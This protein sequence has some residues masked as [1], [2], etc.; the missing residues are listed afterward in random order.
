M[1][2]NF[3]TEYGSTCK[4]SKMGDVYSFGILLLETF[5]GKKP[6]DVDDGESSLREWVRAAL[7]TSLLDVIDA[8]LLKD[9]SVSRQQ[10]EHSN[11]THHCLSSVIELGLLCSS[12]A[13]NERIQMIYVVPRLQK[14]KG[15]YLSQYRLL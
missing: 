11:S 8:N 12:Y 15:E 10:L 2:I 3:V 9:D 6:T 1:T 5:T 13:P 4:V 7:P 14:I